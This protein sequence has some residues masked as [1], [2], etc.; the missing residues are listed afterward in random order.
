MSNQS[1]ITHRHD[2]VRLLEKYALRFFTLLVIVFC[3]CLFY[4]GPRILPSYKEAWTS[5]STSIFASLVF[6]RLYSSLVER[7]HQATVNQEL[8]RDV[9]NAV[10]EIK[11]ELHAFLS[12]VGCDIALIPQ[13]RQEAEQFR[14][15]FLARTDWQ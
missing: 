5:I 15:D 9:R 4:F 13:L 12:Q 14:N 7:H 11:E 3:F 1:G 6:A 2:V 10:E 8:A